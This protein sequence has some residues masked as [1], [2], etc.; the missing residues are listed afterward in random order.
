ML[1]AFMAVSLLSCHGLKDESMVVPEGTL[2]IFADKTKISADGQ[3]VVT[4]RVMFGSQDVSKESTCRLIREFEGDKKYMSY[5]ANEFSTTSPGKYSFTATYYYA[6]NHLTDNSVEIEAE[7][8]YYGET[9][10]YEKRHFA[11]LFTST[12]C[13][14]C[15]FAAK[16]IAELQEKYP[17]KIST[18]SLHSF[19]IASDPMEIEESTLFRS[20]FS[21]TGLPRLFWNMK[22]D[23]DLIGPDFEESFLQ[24][25]SSSSASCGV[26]LRTELS[27]DKSKMDISVGVTSN[28]PL[29]YRY[30]VFIVED[31]IDKYKQTGEYYV[32]NNVVR[33]ILS[34]SPDGDKMNDG[35]P[36]TTGV[37]VTE[38]KTVEIDPEWN[39]DNLRVIACALSSTDGGNTYVVENVSECK[40]GEGTEPGSGSESGTS[41]YNR[42]VCV[43]DLTG[44]WCSFCPSGYSS[45]NMKIQSNPLWKENVKMIAL[46]SNSA[47]TDDLALPV[48]EDIHE[49]LQNGSLSYP[50]YAIDM[51]DSGEPTSEG[52]M[53][54]F[55]EAL[56]RSFEDYPAH[57]GVSVSSVYDSSSATADI[58]VKV[59]SERTETYRVAI[60][61][62]EDRIKYKQND[63]GI[64]KNDY[65]HRHVA[66]KLVTSYQKTFT[67]EKITSDGTIRSGEEAS[68]TWK[69]DVDPVWKLNDTKIYALVM[70]E[71]GYINNMNVCALENGDSGYDL[72]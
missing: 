60:F 18:A 35:L 7:Q 55:A 16:G 24:E 63:Q 11:L 5:G 33:D 34:S 70:G 14:S 58:T 9:T 15:P 13:T 61:V 43:M 50:A 27:A 23:S 38:K 26:A 21:V 36:F 45:M 68:K 1:A 53:V 67:G 66:R 64:I 17:G 65:N 42:Q 46:H 12:E 25:M 3:D 22:K 37:K 30:I 40:A 28:Y 8:F 47:G 49:M 4:F 69:I 52:G 41:K 2:R 31:G 72:K 6:G 29:I 44:A 62:I 56:D 32:H 57:C 48:T 19:M 10:D 39:T 20:A 54:A 51:R 59:A 71:N